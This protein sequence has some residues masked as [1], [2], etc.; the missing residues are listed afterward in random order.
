MEN[1]EYYYIVGVYHN[2]NGNVGRKSTTEKYRRTSKTCGDEVLETAYSFYTG[3]V[4][5]R[6]DGIF[7]L[8]KGQVVGVVDKEVA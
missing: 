4:I 6:V 3:D 7:I 1:V 5:C 2:I 8:K